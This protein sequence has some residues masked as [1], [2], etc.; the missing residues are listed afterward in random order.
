MQ[1]LKVKVGNKKLIY[2]PNQDLIAAEHVSRSSA[3][4]I[5]WIEQETKQCY[6]ESVHHYFFTI[7]GSPLV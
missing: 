1:S 5:I 4:A 3:E 2:L 6:F 7:F